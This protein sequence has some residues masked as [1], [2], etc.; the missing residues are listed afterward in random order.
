MRSNTGS[1]PDKPLKEVTIYTDGACS[2]NPG[3]GGYGVV[4]LYQGHRKELSAGFKDTTNNRMEIL[5]AI[6]GLE[7]LKEKCRV[8]LYTDSQYLVNAIEKNWAQKWRANGWMRNKKEPALNADLWA[9]LLKLCEFHEIKFV[10]VKGHAG[11]PEN[12]RCDQLAVAAFKQPG[13]PPDIRTEP[14]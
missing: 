9:R 13:L 11:N 14:V 1:S 2:G 8:T 7:S 5:A 12:E 10:W 6:K 4:L 3:P